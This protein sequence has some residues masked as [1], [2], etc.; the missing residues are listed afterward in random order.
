[1]IH[2]KISFLELLVF[3]RS[4]FVQPPMRG[5]E[6]APYTTPRAVIGELPSDVTLPPLVAVELVTAVLAVVLTE[7]TS[8]TVP[9]TVMLWLVAPLTLVTL[10][11]VVLVP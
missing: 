5:L 8:V 1:M 4:P 2:K 9:N 7:G 10:T 11:G 3:L 6:L